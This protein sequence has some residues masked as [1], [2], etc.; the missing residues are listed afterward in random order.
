MP[1]F[2]QFGNDI[3]NTNQISAFS[4]SGLIITINL[5]S[6]IW[7]DTF[8]KLVSNWNIAYR[9]QESLDQEFNSLLEKLDVEQ[10]Q[11]DAPPPKKI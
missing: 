7:V 10:F 3:I 6:P 2:I 11:I 5:L 1:K 4:K 9:S 8:K